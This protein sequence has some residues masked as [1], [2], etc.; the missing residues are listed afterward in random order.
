MGRRPIAPYMSV[1][2]VLGLGGLFRFSQDVRMAQVVGLFFS[3]VACGI[4]S[5]GFVTALRNNPRTE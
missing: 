4:S 3:C 5:R 1:L 2:L